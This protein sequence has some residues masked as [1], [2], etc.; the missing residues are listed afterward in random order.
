MAESLGNVFYPSLNRM[1]LEL[2]ARSGQRVWRCCRPMRAE[3]A[4]KTCRRASGPPG[5]GERL[6]ICPQPACG[7]HRAGYSA[8]SDICTAAT[9]ADHERL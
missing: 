4:P 5:G 3:S 7:Q 6:L 8:L 1:A 9:K 2:A